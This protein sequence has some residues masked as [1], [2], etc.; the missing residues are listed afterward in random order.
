MEV[1][2]LA[3][4]SLSDQLDLE[5]STADMGGFCLDLC[6]VQLIHPDKSFVFHPLFASEQ[7]AEDKAGNACTEELLRFLSGTLAQAQALCSVLASMGH[8]IREGDMQCPHN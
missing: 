3:T 7:F 6:E 1:S 4:I 5:H 2:K 8:S